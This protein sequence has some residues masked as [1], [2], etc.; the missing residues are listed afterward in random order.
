[1][2]RKNVIEIE[3]SDYIWKVQYNEVV[4]LIKSIGLNFVKSVV[5]PAFPAEFR[6]S[7]NFIFV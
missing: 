6:T 4:L 3:L 5:V 7:H 1:M 2:N